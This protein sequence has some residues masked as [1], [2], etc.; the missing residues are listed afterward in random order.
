M[1]AAALV[2]AIVYAVVGN[3]RVESAV[4]QAVNSILQNDGTCGPASTPGKTDKDFEPDKC[5]YNEKG[6]S[7]NSKVKIFFIEIGDNAGLVETVYS[8]GSVKLTATDGAS[9]G[10]TGGVGADVTFGKLEAG[11]KVNFGA[12]LQFDYGSTWSFDGPDGKKNADEFRKGLEDYLADQAAIQNSPTYSIYC[13]FGGCADPPR[14]P[15]SQMTSIKLTGDVSGTLGLSLTNKTGP[16]DNRT[17]ESIPAAQVVGKISANSQWAVNTDNV[18]GDTTYTTSLGIDASVSSQLWTATWG[19]KG[20]SAVTMAITKNKDGKVVGLKFVS[21]TEGGHAGGSAASGSTQAGKNSGGGSILTSTDATT[22]TVITTDLS[23]DAN[24]TAAQQTIANWLGGDT[25]YSWAGAI[26]AGGIDPSYADPKDPFQQLMHDRSKVSAVTYD[27]V[28]DTTAFG[29]NVKVGVA[30]GFDF[31]LSDSES[32]ATAAS[33]L[34]APDASG[35]R[36]PVPYSDCVK[37]SN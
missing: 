21:T 13:A 16:D 1:L 10:A 2:V 8:D 23:I 4:C 14:D 17:G 18:T 6:E 15:D 37:G 22:A 28:K 12:G 5:K 11:A 3:G 30:L 36:K 29:L 32:Q 26:A 34:G 24:D 20:A 7:Y 35:N 27:N 33:Y 19:T 25:N 9:V 31:S